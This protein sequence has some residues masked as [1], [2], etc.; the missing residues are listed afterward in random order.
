[1]FYMLDLEI[2]NILKHQSFQHCTLLKLQC[3]V[4]GYFEQEFYD[5]VCYQK[6][7]ILQQYQFHHLV[8]NSSDQCHYRL[9]TLI[10]SYL[11]IDHFEYLKKNKY[12]LSFFGQQ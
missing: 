2:L 11:G 1:M 5:P 10:W 3:L 6:Q 7:L 12:F 8:S 9:K 4:L